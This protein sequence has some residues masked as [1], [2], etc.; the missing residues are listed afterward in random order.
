MSQGKN[1]V[2]NTDSLSSLKETEPLQRVFIVHE[3]AEELQQLLEIT[4]ELGS[5]N[6]LDEFFQKFA[7]RSAEFLNFERAF[8]ALAEQGRFTVRWIT[9]KHE[10]LPLNLTLPETFAQK[11]LIG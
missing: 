8:I 7:V 2:A 11:L 5:V 1:I 10:V 6:D 3:R 4:S 9:E